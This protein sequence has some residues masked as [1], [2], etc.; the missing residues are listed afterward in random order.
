MLEEFLKISE[1]ITLYSGKILNEFENIPILFIC[2]DQNG[3][4]YLCLCSEIRYKYH[5]TI[6]QCPLINISSMIDKKLTIYETF[7]YG[8]RDI[9]YSV[10][11]IDKDNITIIKQKFEDVNPL[12]LPER[13]LY[14]NIT[15]Y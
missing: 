15:N 3:T 12:D 11:Y 6:V 2:Y 10:D 1:N 8:T 7:E 13:N 5:Y 14:Y 4:S 9:I